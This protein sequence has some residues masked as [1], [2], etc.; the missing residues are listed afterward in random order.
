[1]YAFVAEQQVRRSRQGR[2][3]I[4]SDDR[5]HTSLVVSIYDERVVVL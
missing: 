3:L 4:S 1:M 2:G 5:G